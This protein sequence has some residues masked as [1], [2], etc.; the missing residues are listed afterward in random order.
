[1]IQVNPSL[2][3]WDK[4]GLAFFLG[5]GGL[6]FFFASL[7][8]LNRYLCQNFGTKCFWCK[9]FWVGRG[10]GCIPRYGPVGRGSDRQLGSEAWQKLDLD[11]RIYRRARF[12][13]AKYLEKRRTGRKY[14]SWLWQSRREAY[15][16]CLADYREC[17]K[18]GVYR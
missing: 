6:C 5:F 17:R 7:N 8:A 14:D 18:R 12:S 10:C 2:T 9:K 13:H 16:R 15:L 1:M 3:F 4:V 11:E